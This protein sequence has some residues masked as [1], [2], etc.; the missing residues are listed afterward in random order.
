MQIELSRDG[1]FAIST[2]YK[3][4]VERR[5]AGMTRKRA[6]Y[7]DSD[8]PSEK[9]LI[10]FV[11]DSTAE[12]VTAGLIKQF[13][14]GGIELLPAGIT[15]MENLPLKTLKEWLSFGAQFLP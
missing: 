11:R 14:Y 10:D 5:K 2:I 12:L 6:I 1:K 3:A 15:F 9:M 7:F 13:I 8:N 4:H